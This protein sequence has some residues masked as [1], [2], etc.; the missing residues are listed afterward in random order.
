MVQALLSLRVCNN[1]CCSHFG[2]IA[3]KSAEPYTKCKVKRHKVII[4]NI[5]IRLIRILF[6]GQSD[7][8]L[9]WVCSVY[10][11]YISAKSES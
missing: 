2:E 4:I 8:G 1:V 5:V 11:D 9:L 7:L 10:K 6:V 3:G